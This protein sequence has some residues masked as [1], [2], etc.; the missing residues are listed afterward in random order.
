MKEIS[1]EQVIPPA[2]PFFYALWLG[3]R[4]LRYYAQQKKDCLVIA[5]YLKSILFTHQG[6]I[7]S[8]SSHPPVSGQGDGDNQEHDHANDNTQEK[9]GEEGCQPN[10]YVSFA[11]AFVATL[12]DI[13]LVGLL[14]ID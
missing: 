14:R 1:A 7:S 5:E 13:H 8:S 3:S 9:K 2:A 11:V 12:V 10:P 6:I 4:L